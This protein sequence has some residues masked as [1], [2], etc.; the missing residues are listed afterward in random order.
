MRNSKAAVLTS[1][2]RLEIWDLK[3]PDP[4]PGGVLV[5]VTIAGVCGT[6][7]HILKGAYNFDVPVTLGHEGV[8]VLEMLGPGV[9]TDYAGVPVKPG[10]QVYWAP[11]ALCHRCHSCVILEDTPCENSRW[12][13][14]ARKPGWATYSE[15]AWLPAGLAFF[16]LPDH[17]SAEAVAA[18][19]CALPT[20]LRAYERHGAVVRGA[21]VVVLGAGAVGLSCVLLAR[22]GGART[23]VAVDGSPARLSAARD[24]GATATVDL[25]LDPPERTHRI[26][27]ASGRAGA[28]LVIEAAGVLSAFSDAFDLV[29]PHGAVLVVGLGANQNLVEMRPG[30]LSRRNLTITGAAYPKPRHYHEAMCLAAEQDPDM[31]SRL[32]THRYP[33]DQAE[34]ALA[35]VASGEAIKAVILP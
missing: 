27:E 11:Y 2:N 7:L 6:D 23:I 30:A 13:Q 12:Y 24:L 22:N 5:K 21:D 33:I 25:S 15:Y 20:A 26:L 35:T 31:L 17:A 16:R 28:T 29:A 3:L 4:E 8:G 32:I 19:G 18:L 14:D 1:P 9:T 10:D 34:A